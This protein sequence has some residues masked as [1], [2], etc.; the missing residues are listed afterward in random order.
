VKRLLAVIVVASVAGV[1][2]HTAGSSG[3]AVQ[4]STASISGEGLGF[5]FTGTFTLDHF[6]VV[7]PAD[8]GQLPELIVP[9]L[10]AVGTTSSQ[11]YGALGNLLF[12]V[13]N[14]PLVWVNVGI[15][16][17]C[18]AV[19]VALNA[20]NGGD[21]QTLHGELLYP[22]LPQPPWNNSIHW[23]SA[24]SSITI[25]GSS[26]LMCAAAH[27]AQAGGPPSAL[28]QVLNQLLRQAG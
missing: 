24:P 28:A 1:A 3:P 27:L 22:D 13:T 18:D 20:L 4:V 17:S 14:A 25:S 2:A 19:Q 6:A 23:G 12:S 5:T 15:T 11:V 9:R 26:G 16:G 21:Y 7:T 8:V 10:V